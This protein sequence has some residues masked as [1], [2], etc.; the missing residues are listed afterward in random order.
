MHL[1]TRGFPRAAMPEL[2]CDLPPVWGPREANL[3]KKATI[4][5]YIIPHA[6]KRVLETAGAFLICSGVSPTLFQHNIFLAFLHAFK[7][8]STTAVPAFLM[9]LVGALHSMHPNPH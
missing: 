4:Y 3:D 6:F 5:G 7:T 9:G 2:D 1:A 8:P